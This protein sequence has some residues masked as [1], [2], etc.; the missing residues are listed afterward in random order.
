[1]EQKLRIR[2]LINRIARLDGVHAWEQGLNPTQNAV[3]YYLDKANRFSRSPSHVAD[4]LGST[5]GTIS[6]TFKSLAQKGYVTEKRSSVDKRTIS[7]DLTQKGIDAVNHSNAV[8]DT[9]AHLDESAQHDLSNT[10]Q[11]ILV[12]LLRNKGGRTFG[13]CKYCKHF[14]TQENGGYCRFLSE[15]L[16]EPET[17]QVCHEQIPA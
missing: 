11:S 5:R 10:L 3:L 16:T 12:R 15:V 7:Y 4:Y 1:M 14:A 17:N 6:Q 8:I 9:I 2:E 13:L